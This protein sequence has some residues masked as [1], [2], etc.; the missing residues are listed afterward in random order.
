MIFDPARSLVLTLQRAAH[1]VLT[2]FDDQGRLL[3]LTPSEMNVLANLMGEHAPTAAELART[4]GLR[5]STLTGVLDRLEAAELVMRA[6][7][8]KDRR[9]V[10]L[11]LTGAGEAKAQRLVAHLREY[12]LRLHEVLPGAALQGFHE[13]S[14][15][16]AQLSNDAAVAADNAR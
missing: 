16:I 10:A 6:R 13:V 1:Q 8:P 2:A 12:E 14:S 5:P 7:H 15:A 3:E 11:R 9:A 4:S